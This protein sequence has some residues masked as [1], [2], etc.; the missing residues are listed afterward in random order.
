M[1]TFLQWPPAK[2]FLCCIWLKWKMSVICLHFYIHLSIQGNNWTVFSIY[3]C[4][5]GKRSLSK[6]AQERKKC[7]DS[8]TINRRKLYIIIGFTILYNI[9]FV[10]FATYLFLKQ[11]T[12]ACPVHHMCLYSFLVYLEVLPYT[13]PIF[14]VFSLLSPKW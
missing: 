1:F 13:C 9:Q 5:F 7:Y 8:S 4:H 14:V 3:F 6:Q 12:Y 10:Y 2:I 11:V